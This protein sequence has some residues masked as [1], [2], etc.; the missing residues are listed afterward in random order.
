AYGDKEV[1]FFKN[2][3]AGG[4]GSVRGFESNSLGPRDTLTGDFLGGTRRV[5][6]NTELLFGL[7]G[8]KQDRSFR[9]SVFADVGGVFGEGEKMSASNFR[10]STGL[11]ASWNS[12]LGPLKFSFAKPLNKKQDD[13][14]QAFQF[15]LGST[16]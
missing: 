6:G 11:S 13:K 5:I 7:P 14:V 10:F 4:I 3:Y 15:Q 2:F 16:F 8:A 12:P 1:P 9:F